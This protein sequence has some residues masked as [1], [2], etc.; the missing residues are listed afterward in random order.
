MLSCR[1]SL[2]EAKIILALWEHTLEIKPNV[3]VHTFKDHPLVTLEVWHHAL[4]HAYKM[5]KEKLNATTYQL[6]GEPVALDA[7]WEDMQAVKME[8][9][10]CLMNL[11]KV[12]KQ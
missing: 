11:N 10:T 12:R 2:I 3:N 9:D 7:F 1:L 4:K 6:V 5:P 8:L